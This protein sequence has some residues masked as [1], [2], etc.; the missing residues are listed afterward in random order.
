MKKLSVLA[1]VLVFALSVGLMAGAQEVEKGGTLTIASG[2]NFKDLNPMVSNAV[3]DFYVINQIFDNLLALD[4]DTLEPKPFV[5]KDWDY[6]E[7]RTEITF[8]LNEGIKFHNGEKLTSEDVAFTFNWILNPENGS[9]NRSEFAWLKE[10]EIIDEY[11]VKF[12]TKEDYAPYAPGLV[13]ETFAI[14]PKDTF[15]EMGREK[16]NQNPVGSGPFEFVEWKKGDHITVEKN[17]DYWLKDVNLDKVIFRPIPKI[18]TM[19][20]E[21]EKGGVDITDTMEP[22]QVTKF[23]DMDDV[24]V[25]QTPGL[26]YFYVAFN[27]NRSPYKNKKFREAVYKSFSMTEAINSIFNSTAKTAERAYGSIPPA[28]WGNDREYLKNNVALEEDDKEAGE[29]FATLREQGVL[30]N[31]KTVTVY[32]PPDPN[33]K[34]LATIMVTNLREHGLKAETQPLEWGAYLDLLYRS[35][36][37][38]L[39]SDVDIFIIGWS[40]SPDPNSFT[41]YLFETKDNTDLGAMNNMAGYYDPLVQN[42]IMRSQSTMDQEKRRKLY[43]E[44]QRRYM[45]EYVH[46]PAYHQIETRGVNS[47]VHDYEPDPLSNMPLVNPFRNVWVESG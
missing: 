17:E 32:S 39:G 40:G 1:L 38:P 30:D 7:D 44:A 25:M 22:V 21:L 11:T 35:N 36:E 33:R 43:V 45:S 37:D 2:Q 4:P 5:A 19:M 12:V 20:L 46:I 10:V 18:A 16:F 26:N 8:Y 15:L 41:Y 27:M 29:L 34:K 3:Y 6:S 23:Q 24:K 47:R 42:R 9:P 14:V 28:L 31:D 13:A